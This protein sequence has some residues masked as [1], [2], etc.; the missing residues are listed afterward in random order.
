MLLT[1]AQAHAFDVRRPMLLILAEHIRR[2]ASGRPF[3]D[4]PAAFGNAQCS[5][6]IYRNYFGI[7]GNYLGSVTWGAGMPSTP[8]GS[9]GIT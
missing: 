9:I 5:N 6:G 8:M 1:Y 7:Y 2:A 3:P 4:G